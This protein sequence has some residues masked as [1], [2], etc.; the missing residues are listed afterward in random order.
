MF[1]TSD[2]L[3]SDRYC[4]VY[5]TIAEF[6]PQ[7]RNMPIRLGAISTI[8]YSPYRSDPSSLAIKIVATEEITVEITR[9]QRRWK[10]PFAEILAMSAALLNFSFATL[11]C[12]FI[13]YTD[14]SLKSSS[15]KLLE[16]RRLKWLLSCRVAGK[17]LRFE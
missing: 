6:M 3:S 1:L 10:L 2:A 8:P 11:F 15:L 13:D 17:I 4:A 16:K 12:C 5:R 14:G 9:P 7:S